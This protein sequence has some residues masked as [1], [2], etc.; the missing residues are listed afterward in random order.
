MER[1]VTDVTGLAPLP[2]AFSLL[3]VFFAAVLRGY[4]GFGFSALAV[5]ALSLVMRPSAVV[6][7]VLLLEVAASIHLFPAVRGHVDWRVMRWL[8]PA[9]AI[10]MPAGA[11][12][13]ASLP[14][15]P[16]RIAISLTVLG[17][18][19]LI[20]LKPGLRVP[21]DARGIVPA[22]LVSG[23]LNGAAALGGL[24]MILYFLWSGVGPATLRATVIVYFLY[25]DIYAIGIA[26]GYGLVGPQ[27]AIMAAIM[28]LPLIAGNAVG[29]KR[30]LRSNPDS[31][32]R[33]T[34]ILLGALS[35]FGV[36]HSLAG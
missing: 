25:S 26:T 23:A 22:G 16:M 17:L 20:W 13:L 33:L 6:P 21:S 14:A 8:L 18:T 9:A 34:L 36:V 32:R 28:L 5:T 12:F 27:T 31:F 4:S 1:I 35:A 30:F 3:V 15:V 7:V 11:W 2:L 29:H 19:L 10:A 24:P